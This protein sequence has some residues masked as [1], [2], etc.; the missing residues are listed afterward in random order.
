[1]GHLD[2][3]Y[4]SHNQMVHWFD[5]P[6]DCLDCWCLPWSRCQAVPGQ[7]RRFWLRIFCH[8]PCGM[9][10][11][12]TSL[13]TAATWCQHDVFTNFHAEFSA[14]LQSQTPRLGPAVMRWR[15]PS[16]RQGLWKGCAKPD[17]SNPGQTISSRLGP[18]FPEQSCDIYSLDW[19]IRQQTIHTFC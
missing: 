2:H 16:S 5:I 12:K 3:G 9:S 7:P 14:G 10:T 6:R 4:V 11:Q 18:F 15:K 17:D 13:K 1:M 19:E 8:V